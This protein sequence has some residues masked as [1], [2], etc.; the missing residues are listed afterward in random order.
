M[1]TPP[2]NLRISAADLASALWDGQW[3][4]PRHDPVSAV[5]L[6]TYP[7]TAIP[8]R[9]VPAD[10]PL[11]V[12]W[13]DGCGALVTDADSGWIAERFGPRLGARE[14]ARVLSRT[15]LR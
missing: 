14:L 9:A 1:G 3:S 4:F 13:E 8:L 12:S 10:A 15:R 11:T 6:G 7:G 5:N 2:G